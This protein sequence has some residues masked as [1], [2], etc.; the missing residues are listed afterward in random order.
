MNLE[1]LAGGGSL[2]E[3][4]RANPGAHTSLGSAQFWPQSLRTT[5]R[6]LLGTQHPS[7]RGL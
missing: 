6:V 1:F 3:R 5:V 7:E 4:I 2:D